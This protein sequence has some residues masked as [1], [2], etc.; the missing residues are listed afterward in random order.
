VDLRTVGAGSKVG[1]NAR[2]FQNAEA[3]SGFGKSAS[4]CILRG[5]Q[6]RACLEKQNKSRGVD[7][8]I[9]R[10]KCSKKS[11]TGRSRFG[12]QVPNSASRLPRHASHLEWIK[13][14]GNT[15]RTPRN[16][17]HA[18]LRPP[19]RPRPPR[20]A[21][22]S[23]GLVRAATPRPPPL[24]ALSRYERPAAPGSGA[25]RALGAAR[26][27]GGP[28]RDGGGRRRVVRCQWARCWRPL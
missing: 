21:A 26:R 24:G 17:R 22:A 13:F 27:G 5:P 6:T 18:L 16:A 1:R 14:C 20:G 2:L 11:Q 4:A 8:C 9:F 15:P 28:E 12:G 25:C 3:E 7:F 10:P 19:L 23:T